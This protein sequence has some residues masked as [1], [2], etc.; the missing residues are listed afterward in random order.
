MMDTI[1]IAPDLKEIRA[2]A[3]LLAPFII[4]TPLLRLNAAGCTGE[5]YLKLENLQP[6]GAYKVRS[7][8]SVLLA[9]DEAD[10]RH[11]AYT[12]SSGNAG[13][14]LAWMA[15]KLGVP[16]RVYVPEGSPEAKLEAIRSYGADIHLLSNDDWWRIIENSGHPTD[17]GLYVDAVRDPAA[18]AGNGTI[19]L[20]IVE[21]LPDVDRIIVPFGGGGIVCGIASAIRAMKPDTRIIIAESDAAI[22]ATAAF[23]AGK[24]V[25]VSMAPSFIT[26]AGAPL[27]LKEMWPLISELVDETRVVAVSEVAAAIRFL[28]SHNH[29]VAEGAGAISVAAALAEPEMNGKTVCVV[30]G[31]NIDAQVMASI[32]L[33]QL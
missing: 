10:L 30:S 25:S 33:H 6:I 24:P 20:E 7:M 5:I 19:G 1:P 22:P 11:G 13:V 31:G 9:A 28:F 26:G 18:L 8:G 12:A 32:L 29:I 14:G 27:V 4:R 3:N 15:Q 21:Q 16:A 17:P 2:A 23:K